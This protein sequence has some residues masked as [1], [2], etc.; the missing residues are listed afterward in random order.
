M[1][2]P[3]RATSLLLIAVALTTTV[4]AAANE[5]AIPV[6]A[7]NRSTPVDFQKEILPLLRENCLAC[8]NRTKAK[9]GL[10]LETPADIRKGGDS[11]PSALP[12]KGAASP[13]DR[14]PRGASPKK[15]KADA[16]GTGSRKK[17]AARKSA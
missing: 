2:F 15:P 14:S 13:R 8:H 3:P 6:L 5:H 11:G 9:A 7:T 10:V 12:G 1:T 16:S 17:A 4:R